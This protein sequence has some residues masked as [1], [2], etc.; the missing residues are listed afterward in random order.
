MSKTNNNDWSDEDFE[1]I[2][3]KHPRNRKRRAW[4]YLNIVLVIFGMALM[5]LGIHVGYSNNKSFNPIA[6]SN[7][8][9][10][11]G[12]GGVFIAFCGYACFNTYYELEYEFFRNS[13]LKLF[14]GV[15]G[16]LSSILLGLGFVYM[17]GVYGWGI[18]EDY[19]KYKW[20]VWLIGNYDDLLLPFVMIIFGI[21]FAVKR[22]WT[23]IK[24]IAGRTIDPPV[25]QEE[26]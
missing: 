10:F 2:G 23:S 17:G 24:I 25:F 19:T 6:T 7:I 11:M 4:L 5:I 16:I 8:I 13:P 3:K 9:A 1:I 22:S 18:F 15:T 26:E 21:V 20:W 12:F 14:I